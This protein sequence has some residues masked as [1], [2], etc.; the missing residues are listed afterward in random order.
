MVCYNKV[1]S[2][3]LSINILYKYINNIAIFTKNTKTNTIKA[4]NFCYGTM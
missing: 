1:S 4:N 3:Q 2:T